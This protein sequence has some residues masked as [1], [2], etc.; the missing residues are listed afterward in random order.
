MFIPKLARALGVDEEIPEW[1]NTDFDTVYVLNFNQEGRMLDF[2]I[3]R[4]QY[5]VSEE[6]NWGALEAMVS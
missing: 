1:S 4:D 5:P 3:L 6:L 2:Q